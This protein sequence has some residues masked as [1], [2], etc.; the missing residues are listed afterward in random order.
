[1]SDNLRQY[2]T[3]NYAFA[4]D[5]ITSNL[6]GNREGLDAFKSEMKGVTL[7]EA[8]TS[9][10]LSGFIPQVFADEVTIIGQRMA[11][12]RQAFSAINQ[13]SNSSFKIR[14]REK[15]EG[16]Q[17]LRELDEFQHSKSDRYTRE[18]TFNKIGDFPLFS[19]ELLEDS[20]L[21]EVADEVRMSVSKIWRRENQLA[22]DMVTRFSQGTENDFW[23]NWIEGPFCQDD[24]AYPTNSA[25]ATAIL[26]AMEAAYLDITTRLEDAFPQDSL[27]W[28]MSPTTFS[29]LWKE[30]TFRRFDAL[31]ATPVQ[32]TGNLPTPFG[33]PMSIIETGYF[34]SSSNYISAPC[35]IYLM[36]D[37]SFRLRERVSL[38]TQPITMDKIQAT[39]PLMWERLCFYPRNPLGLRR[40]SPME[41]YANQITSNANIK[42]L[43]KA[44]V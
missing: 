15:N 12:A 37:Q 27:R 7:K 19:F 29:I 14:F 39:G 38:R 43:A 35:D 3:A 28:F 17:I 44:D 9:D 16:A 26:E 2:E 25:K 4:F 11:T 24:S 34:D 41:D 13:S 31:G 6:A 8:M 21:D 42:I 33:L 22:W 18:F 30:P 40:I 1:M 23:G 5:N 32:V 10:E 36:S 20:P